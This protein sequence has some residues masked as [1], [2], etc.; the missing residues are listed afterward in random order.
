MKFF[1]KKLILL[2]ISGVCIL[3]GFSQSV[4][5]AK[6]TQEQLKF[7]DMELGV[8]IHYSIDTYADHST[9][10]GKTPASAFNPTA[11][12]VEQWV[13]AAKAMG[14]KYVVLTARHEQG[15]CL[16]P[17]KTTNYS[18]KY[19]PYK[20]GKGDI[21]KEFVDACKK[22]GLKP[23]LYTAPWIDSHWENDHGIVPK[24][25]TGDINKLNDTLVFK[26]RLK[27]EKEQIHELMTNYGPLVFIWDD[28]FGRSDAISDKPQ[29]GKLREFYAAFSEYAH[30]LQPHCLLLGRDIEHVGNEKGIAS[31]PLWNALN[32]VDGTIYS[33]STTYKWDHPNTGTPTGKFYRPQIAPT[34]VAFS[35]GGWMWSG[36]RNPQPLDSIIHAYYETIG[37]GS[38][39]IVNLTPD[40]RGLIPDDL[41]SAA[42][43][44]GKEITKRFAHPVALSESK[45]SFQLLKFK[46]PVTFNQVVTME[47]ISK[48]QNI[49]A[50]TIEALIK[51]K[52]QV[53]V[54]GISIGHKRIDSFD[55]VTATALRFKV[56]KSINS[57][58]V[59][60]N[61][62]VYNIVTD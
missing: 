34:T 52:W 7:Q 39:L 28:H 11:L 8:F 40:K 56:T 31:Y 1:I 2:F 44:F 48:G 55:S 32:T 4:Y 24:G 21:V 18:I 35:Q 25:G 42:E 58:A 20:N 6:P 19:S 16:W 60:R 59:M 37:R 54:N 43:K 14:A 62:S 41:V 49:E 3:S 45:E 23:G 29:G 22:Y 61:I 26:E 53:I 17:T 15:F 51:D 30:E 33:I 50:Y 57:S 27:K 47:D 12:N 46:T 5:L 9:P 36:K 38:G 13:K 10:Q